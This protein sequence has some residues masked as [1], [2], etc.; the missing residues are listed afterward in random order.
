[1]IRAA[2]ADDADAVAALVE[3]GFATWRSFAPAGWEPPQQQVPGYRERITRAGNWGLVAEE[4]GA[5]VGHVA[6]ERSE[7]PGLAA[8]LHARAVAEAERQGYREMRLYVPALHARAH[9]FYEREGWRYASAAVEAPEI[10][11]D[12]VELR[13]RPKT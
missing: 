11:V 8:E 1:M 13:R 2:R 5:V 7:I 4:S 9:R 6:F 3:Q 10:G 12:L